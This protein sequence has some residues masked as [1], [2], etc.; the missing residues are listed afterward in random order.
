MEQSALWAQLERVLDPELDESIVRLG[1]VQRLEQ[2]GSAVRVVLR[3]PTYWCSPNFVYLM[4]DGVRRVLTELPGIESVRVEL[5]EH[6]ASEEIS[7]GV[8]SGRS[9]RE[10]FPTEAQEELDELRCRF[11]VKGYASRL[12]VLVQALRS[13]GASDD[14]LVE[15]SLGQLEHTGDL[16]WLVLD[17]R[18]RGPVRGRIVER[19]LVRRAELGLPMLPESPLLLLADGQPITRERLN[20]ELRRLRTTVINLRASTALCEALLQ[21]RQQWWQSERKEVLP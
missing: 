3:L 16:A 9:F 5:E 18:R 15:S 11:L 17:D 14:E 7:S 2:D 21:S 10:L 13:A 1:F 4:A 8:T 6:F 19:Y 20:E 12:L